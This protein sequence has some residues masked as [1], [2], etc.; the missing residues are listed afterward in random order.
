MIEDG[1]LISAVII[2]G[3]VAIAALAHYW[4]GPK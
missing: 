4:W 1:L 2:T 3:A